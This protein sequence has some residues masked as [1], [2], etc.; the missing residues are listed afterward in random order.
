VRGDQV[1]IEAWREPRL[2]DVVGV[3]LGL[4]AGDWGLSVENEQYG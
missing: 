3:L 2:G 1:R 4:A